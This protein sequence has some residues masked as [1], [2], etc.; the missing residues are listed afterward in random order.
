LFWWISKKKEKANWVR[1]G[2]IPA[3]VLN[4]FAYI[5]LYKFPPFDAAGNAAVAAVLIAPMAAYIYEALK[6]NDAGAL[7]APAGE[8]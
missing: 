4:V 5:V 2:I 6:G 1:A 8:H 3:A 7:P